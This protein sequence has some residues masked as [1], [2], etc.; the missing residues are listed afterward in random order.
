M[1]LSKSKYKFNPG[2]LNMAKE[3]EIICREY[4]FKAELNNS[5][6]AEKLLD[7]LPVK[8]TTN[9]WGDEIYFSIPLKAKLEHGKEVMEV[10]EIAYWPPGTAFCIFFGNTPASEN[11]KPKA[12]SPVTPLGKITDK[13]SLKDL[14]KIKSG[15]EVEIRLA[16]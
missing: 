8:S 6:T 9:R 2:E 10:G 15:K 12:A 16:Q 13:N 11:E 14:K 4:K 7:I 5:K 1:R 3:I